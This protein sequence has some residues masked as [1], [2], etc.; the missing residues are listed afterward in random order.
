MDKYVVNKEEIQKIE[1]YLDGNAKS[2]V[3]VLLKRFEVLEQEDLTPAQL[4]SLYKKLIKEHVY[5]NS[6][7]VKAFLK[8]CLEIGTVVFES[9]EIKN[10]K[11]R[12]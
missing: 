11:E 6:R 3:G 2:L 8:L 12:I 9:K 7:Q 10:D 5:E 4:K 1:T